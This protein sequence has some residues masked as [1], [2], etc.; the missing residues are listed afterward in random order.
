VTHPV[1]SLKGFDKIELQP[2]EEK[3]VTFEIKEEMLRL[4]NIDMKHV[5]EPG[6]F[7]VWIGGN[8][9]TENRAEFELRCENE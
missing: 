4:W 8:S 6:K 7:E 3:Q 2:G 5:S 9:L 1:R